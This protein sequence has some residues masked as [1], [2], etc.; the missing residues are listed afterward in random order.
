MTLVCL[1]GLVW[2]LCLG[3]YFINQYSVFDSMYYSINNKTPIRY[4]MK[5]MALVRCS[6]YPIFTQDPIHD[7][8]YV[9]RVILHAKIDKR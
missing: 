5:Y 3:T 9:M 8:R 1:P 2:L 6:V 7:S 4:S